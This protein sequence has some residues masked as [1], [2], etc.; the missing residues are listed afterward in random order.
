S[1]TILREAYLGIVAPRSLAAP[2]IGLLIN[3][4]G[5]LV[6]G[7]WGVFLIRVGRRR[8]SLVLVADGK[9]LLTDVATS[10]GVI[11]GLA[12]AVVTGIAVL[13]PLL[14]GLVALNILW[15]GWGLIRQS[16]GGLMDEAVSED[17]LQ[18][19]RK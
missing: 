9:H 7:A 14:A 15:S 16:V 17:L 19:I 4:A 6:N 1:L 12:L 8:R 2:A 5:A 11:V 3:S 10:A 13:D 18:R